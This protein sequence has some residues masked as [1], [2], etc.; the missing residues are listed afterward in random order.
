M[1]IIQD[2]DFDAL[3]YVADVSDNF[4]NLSLKDIYYEINGDVSQVGNFTVLYSTTDSSGNETTE[5]L[6]VKVEQKSEEQTQSNSNNKQKASDNAK[7]QNK[8]NNG[9]P[10]TKIFYIRDYNYNIEACKN[11]AV[12]YMNDQLNKSNAT[13]GELQPYQENDV[14]VGYNVIFK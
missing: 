13:Y 5:T 3:D 11:A 2:D 4:D 9:L 8:I 1:T 7:K 10:S 6:N 12:S 14:I